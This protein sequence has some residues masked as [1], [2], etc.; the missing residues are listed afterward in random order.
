MII[1]TFLRFKDKLISKPSWLH[2]SKKEG[3]YSGLY[4][5]RIELTNW[6]KF[7]IIFNYQ[8]FNG[9]EKVEVCNKVIIY[10]FNRKKFAQF[11]DS[12]E[13]LINYFEDRIKDCKKARIL[14][15]QS[16]FE[17]DHQDPIF[18]QNPHFAVVSKGDPNAIGSLAR[19][20]AITAK[21]HKEI[22][23]IDDSPKNG[24]EEETDDIEKAK[25][26]FDVP[27]EITNIKDTISE[28]KNAI[29]EI[30]SGFKTMAEAFK[31]ITTQPDKTVSITN[32]EGM[33]Q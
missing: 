19:Y 1:L 5:K 28:M 7:I 18:C 13:S 4:V 30:A 20:L 29:K 10:N 31:L 15:E 14:M 33:F 17:I 16:G 2:R 22:R 6:T 32:S 8:D 26:Y 12:K 11:V 24:G 27:D 21:M 3:F 23:E 25:S 9:L